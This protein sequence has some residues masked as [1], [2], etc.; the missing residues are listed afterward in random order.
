MVRY[1]ILIFDGI[2]DPKFFISDFSLGD[3]AL[4]RKIYSIVPGMAMVLP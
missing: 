3:L 2:E 1:K 4:S